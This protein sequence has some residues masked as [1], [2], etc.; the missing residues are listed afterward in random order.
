MGINI[1][2]ISR[3]AIGRAVGDANRAINASFWDRAFSFG[4]RLEKYA[5][6]T[7]MNLR[8]YLA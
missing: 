3:N 2:F 7:E 1:V 6:S 8:I 4:D 5:G